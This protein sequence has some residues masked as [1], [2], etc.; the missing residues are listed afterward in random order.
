[1]C[2]RRSSGGAFFFVQ[3]FELYI[4]FVSGLHGDYEL[5]RISSNKSLSAN[6]NLTLPLP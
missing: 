3:Y 6:L 2:E 5:Y 1:M 4:V